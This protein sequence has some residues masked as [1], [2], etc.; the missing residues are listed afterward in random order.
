MNINPRVEY[1]EWL[2]SF[3]FDKKGQVNY[4]DTLWTMFN[5]PFKSHLP[6]DDNMFDHGINLRYHYAN[7]KEIDDR[8]IAS[9][10]DICDCSILEMMIS[11]AIHM[12]RIMTDLEYG[13]RTRNWFW[14]MFKNLGLDAYD[15]HNFDEDAVID[16]LVKLNDRAY[17]HDGKNGGLFHIENAK[18]ICAM[19]KYGV[20]QHGTCLIF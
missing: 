6:M 20:K 17:D 9:R 2:L 4:K 16:I 11:L 10:I 13:D 5:Y 14:E 12:E 7:E 19:L 18:K 1:F 8:I 3:I 15:C